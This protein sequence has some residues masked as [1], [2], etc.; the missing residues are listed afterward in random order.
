MFPNML[1]GG[2]KS[3]NRRS[4][5]MNMKSL[6]PM[7]HVQFKD[8]TSFNLDP[9]NIFIGEK[10]LKPKKTCNTNS[11]GIKKVTNKVSN[12]SDLI[13]RVTA[14]CMLH[15]LGSTTNFTDENSE[16]H[17]QQDDTNYEQQQ[18]NYNEDEQE[19]DYIET[20]TTRE[21]EI[22]TLIGEV[23]ETV[24]SMK[25]AYV[26]LQEAHCPWDADK[27]RLS[28][29]AVVADMKRL[30]V[31]RERFRRTVGNR[32][33][34]A[35]TIRE[36]VAPY[37]AAMEEMKTEMKNKDAEV[38]SLRQ[39][40]KKDATTYNVITSGRKS[41]S[42]IHQSRR[43]VSCSSQLHR[44][45]VSST[46]SPALTAVP[47]MFE[48]CMHAVK[49]GSRTLSLL[50]LSLMKAAHWDINATVK[51]IT[52]S[53]TNTVGSNKAKYSLESYV[54]RKFFQGFEHETFY[55]DGSLSSVLNADQFRLECFT[56]YSDMKSMD[57]M[58]LLGILPTCMFG[59]FCTN[60]YLSIVHPKMEES[61]FGDLEQRRQ[62]L[63]G[64]H[65]RSQFYGEFLAVAKA[66]WMLHL[67]AFSLDPL[68]S[69]FE[70][71]RGAEFHPEYM[72]SVVRAAGGRVQVVGFP[73]SPGFK[74]GDGY[75]VKARVYLVPKCEL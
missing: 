7:S 60:K 48:A 37:E 9:D 57:P 56:Q 75:V 1:C 12:F 65:P 33:V 20:A 25:K 6:E 69:H 46:I 45:S 63:A 35:A 67:V 10:P 38:E 24:S 3:H 52:G 29:V 70:G 19:Q 61:L 4:L 21:M 54:N 14:S 32:R 71:S 28:D 58:E 27:I 5:K 73:V 62:V 34:S 16:Y 55:I 26:S 59:K 66:V 31:L 13:H 49:E 43:R 30:G 8:T 44:H 18:D 17:D 72:E 68:P 42:N 53:T 11:R 2:C 39:K 64:N 50:L 51:S 47:D 74:L 22:M 23:F 15:P 40:L 41:R 36:V